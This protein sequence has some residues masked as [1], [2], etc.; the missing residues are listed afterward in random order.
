M[1]TQKINELISE[2]EA[3]HGRPLNP[4]EVGMVGLRNQ[5]RSNKFDD[6]FIYFYKESG[7]WVVKEITKF[8]TDPGFLSLTSPSNS[9]GTAILKEGFYK[10]CWKLGTH[11]GYN[12][13]VQCR[14]VTV[15]RDSNRDTILDTKNVPTDTGLFGINIHR[16]SASK[17]NQVVDNWS[18]GCQV[19]ANPIQ[20]ANFIT[21][22]NK[23]A[24]L[25]KQTYYS[26]LLKQ[27]S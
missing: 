1:E 13:L 18:A 3:R 4:Y 21:L 17:E 24:S 10:D 26:Y 23:N 12:A 20:F 9:K 16:A 8:T 22:L 19:F 2:F 25:S 7:V 6:V 14:S 15:Y 5:T 27:L 11:K